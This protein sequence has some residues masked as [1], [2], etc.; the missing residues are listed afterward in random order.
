VV[1]LSTIISFLIF[2]I[3]NLPA[4]YILDNRGI[5]F[6][7]L[8]GNSIYLLGIVLSCCINIGFPF[9]MIGY[10]FFTIGQPFILNIP[11]KIAT[12]WFF[13]ENVQLILLRDHW[14]LR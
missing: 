5:K 13:P 14:P 12:Y 9:V 1:N 7:F 11:A 2:L 4:N 8:I 6:G 3:V 10:L